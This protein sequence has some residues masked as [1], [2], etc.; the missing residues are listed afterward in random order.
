MYSKLTRLAETE[1]LPLGIASM[2][3]YVVLRLF[4]ANVEDVG[5]RISD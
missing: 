1:K 4:A 3:Y 5:K 2:L